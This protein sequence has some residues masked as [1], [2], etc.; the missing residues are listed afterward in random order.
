MV[1]DVTDSAPLDAVKL[2]S[3]TGA[4]SLSVIV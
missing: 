1:A 2:K 4:L 3:T